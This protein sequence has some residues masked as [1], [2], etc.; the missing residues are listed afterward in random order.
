M[1]VTTHAREFRRLYRFKEAVQPLPT[2]V[3]SKLFGG[4]QEQQHSTAGATSA[5][6][7][8]PRASH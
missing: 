7:P 3:A 2:D 5:K 1:H 8:L 4:R 6:Q